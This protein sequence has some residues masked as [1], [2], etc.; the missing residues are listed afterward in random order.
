MN[1]DNI[2]V[3]G[4]LRSKL[5][6]LTQRQEVLAENIANA[7]TPDYRAQDLDEAKF[8]DF[9]NNGAPRA[10]VRGRHAAHFDIGGTSGR[11]DLKAVETPGW[12]STP[13]GNSVVLEQ[14]M[15]QVAQTQME[16]QSAIGL[17]RKSMDLIRIAISS[18]R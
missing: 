18:G 9:V 4:A 17:Y 12:E 7:N 1:L 3:L 16:Y 6:W 15:M 10:Q 2:P 11:L 5:A 8:Q 14:Q 13:D